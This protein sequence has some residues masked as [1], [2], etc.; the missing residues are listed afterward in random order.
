MWR[1]VL[2]VGAV[3]AGCLIASAALA[4]SD[5]QFLSDAIKGDNAE[6]ALGQ[7]AVRKGASD[8]VR[9]FAQML[10]DDH[11]RGK[12]E[13]TAPPADLDVK[14]TSGISPQVQGEIDTLQ[15]ATGP[16]FDKA[17]VA[18]MV[19]DHEKDIAAFKEKA[20]EGDRPVSALARKTLPVLEKHL[21]LARSLND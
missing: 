7:L 15:R 13:P 12:K 14:V 9:S 21:Q 1:E 5:K 20:G 11:G 3:A 17:F 4:Q 2:F 16:D 10:I 6:I 19:S 8:G 18:Y